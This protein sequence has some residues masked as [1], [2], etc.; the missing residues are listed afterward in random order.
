MAEIRRG[1]IGKRASSR[2]P[3]NSTSGVY[4]T[5]VTHFTTI[6]RMLISDLGPRAC[7]F[8]RPSTEIL[9]PSAPGTREPE[10][11]GAYRT[12]AGN[13]RTAA[14]SRLYGVSRHILR[15]TNFASKIGPP[16]GEI[17]HE[18]SSRG[19]R[20]CL[21]CRKRA[22]ESGPQSAAPECKS[23]SAIHARWKT[24]ASAGLSP[25]GIRLFRIW[26][27]LQPRCGWK[28]AAGVYQCFCNTF[29]I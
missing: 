22:V 27:E 25:L 17:R 28:R 6:G 4:S 3:D 19:A 8:V 11:G 1:K 15:G 10:H 7:V 2:N 14:A 18:T 23:W 20:D 13:I 26:N 16:V 24:G 21:S 29:V 5:T 9:A 12:P